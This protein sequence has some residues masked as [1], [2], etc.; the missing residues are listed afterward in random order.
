MAGLFAGTSGFAY[1]NW[2]PAFYPEELPARQFLQY[3]AGRLNS[4]E[5]NYTFRRLPAAATLESWVGATPPG[6]LFA[7]KAHMRITHVLRLKEA[8]GFLEVFLKATDPLRSVKRLGPILFQLPPDMRLN[9][10]LLAAFL[11]EL[12]GDLRC[13]FEFRHA[14]WLTDEVYEMLKERNACLCLA[15]SDKFETPE[16]LTAG[17]YYARLRRGQYP[18]EERA[19]IG[20][21]A[22]ALVAGGR[23]VFIYFK[24]EETADGAMYAEELLR[25]RSG[26]AAGATGIS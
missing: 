8:A 18:S 11:K 19:E 16:V 12:P 5:I 20:R 24:H 13:V 17:F 7:L 23:D 22:E 3:Y 26:N 6:F 2:K 21:K 4:V 10:E 25:A 14:S 9:T 1:P 15:E